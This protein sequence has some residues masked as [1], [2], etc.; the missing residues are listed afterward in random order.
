MKVALP[1]L[2]TLLLDNVLEI[3]YIRRSPKPGFPPTRRM[4]CTNKASVL[5]S[6][7][8]KKLLNYQQP[9]KQQPKY[10]PVTKNIVV[11]WDILVQDYRC[12]TADDCEVLATIQDDEEFWKYFNEKLYPMTPGDKTKFM[13]T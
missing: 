11:A 2:K 10:N 12:I 4:L 7:P 3:R 6:E 1:T 8:G 9:L 5:L 13:I